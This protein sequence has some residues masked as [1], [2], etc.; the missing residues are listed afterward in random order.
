V[1]VNVG[2]PLDVLARTDA[3]GAMSA[4][5]LLYSGE[6]EA[7]NAKQGARFAQMQAQAQARAALVGGASQAAS[8]GFQSGL[9]S[10]STKTTSVDNPPLENV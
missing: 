10:K 7:W 8:Y 3:E 6:L 9:F 1:D 5:Q 2:S 4:M